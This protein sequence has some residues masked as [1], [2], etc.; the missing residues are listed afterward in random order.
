[1]ICTKKQQS[2]ANIIYVAQKEA[3]HAKKKG[4]VY[5]VIQLSDYI[6]QEGEKNYYVHLR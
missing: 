1:M 2:L 3:T 5:R 4:R 6:A